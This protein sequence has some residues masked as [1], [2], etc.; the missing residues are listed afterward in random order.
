MLS[1][2]GRLMNYSPLLFT[3]LFIFE[4]A[5]AGEIDTHAWHADKQMNPP[6]SLITNAWENKGIQKGKI[7][8]RVK[9]SGFERELEEIITPS[10]TNTQHKTI[11]QTTADDFSPLQTKSSVTNP[12]IAESLMS[13]SALL[14]I[15]HILATAVRSHKQHESRSSVSQESSS[16]SY[17]ESMT[18][19]SHSRFCE[20][21]PTPTPVLMFVIDDQG[22]IGFT[23]DDDCSDVLEP[24]EK[25]DELEGND[26]WIN[27]LTPCPSH[28]YDNNESGA[29]SITKVTFVRM[30]NGCSNS[31]ETSHLSESCTNSEV[32]TTDGQSASTGAP[33][34][35]GSPVTSSVILTPPRDPLCEG[36]A[37]PNLPAKV[38]VDPHTR[39]PEADSCTVSDKTVCEEVY[40]HIELCAGNYEVT[41]DYPSK[42]IEPP[43]PFDSSQVVEDK[44]YSQTP[45]D[46]E[47]KCRGCTY[48]ENRERFAVLERTIKDVIE[49]HP[50]I[51]ICFVINDLYAS[52]CSQ[53]MKHAQAYVAEEFPQAS[54]EFIEFAADIFSVDLQQFHPNEIHLKNPE[55]LIFFED[56]Y[57]KPVI[58]LHKNGDANKRFQKLL[59]SCGQ[60]GIVLVFHRSAEKFISRVLYKDYV[61]TVRYHLD[62]NVQYRYQAKEINEAYDMEKFKHIMGFFCILKQYIAP[63]KYRVKAQN[64]LRYK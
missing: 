21:T 27:I 48:D 62:Y 53:A 54:I 30:S 40:T 58:W 13:L 31:Q 22:G 36:A 26:D 32:T 15:K 60:T 39:E 64:V 50:G 59:N 10:P 55:P 42:N 4:I 14:K 3:C 9:H 24:V 44:V 45:H 11:R 35:T 46:N 8:S 23:E 52:A 49:K 61:T 20:S 28:V 7:S 37:T 63:Q 17:E 34:E 29:S 56:A 6:G 18:L 19:T 25:E 41:D 12:T 16:F 1:K 47:C 51:K 43:K 5:Q 57:S 33:I 2:L 38:R